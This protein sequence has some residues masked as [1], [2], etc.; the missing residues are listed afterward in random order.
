MQNYPK[1]DAYNLR[2][3]EALVRAG[4]IARAAE[5]ENIAA[6]ALSRRLAELE[7]ILRTAL[8]IRSPRG[9]V[10]TPAGTIL[11]KRAELIN[12]EVNQLVREAW[13]MSDSTEVRGF[14]RLWSNPSGLIG[15][16]PELLRSFTEQFPLVDIDLTEDDTRQVMRACL[17]DEADVGIAVSYEVP[18]GLES[19]HFVDD[20]IKVIC[21]QDHPLVALSRTITLADVVTYPLLTVRLG[22]FLDTVIRERSRLIGEDIQPRLTVSSI[23]A[24]CRLIEVG[25]GIGLLPRS[26]L[27][28]YA[29]SSHFAALPLADPWAV[30]NLSIFAARQAARPRAVQA[31]IGHLAA[32]CG[33]ATG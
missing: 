28:S 10:L 25:M 19:W 12:R 17:H 4:S 6:S 16:L 27:R 33:G 11:L 15:Y 20:D 32:Q 22:G 29:G 2:L 7:E 23:D 3:F 30:R 18:A 14:V 26:M 31:L 5:A 24:A 9:L 13:N 1:I 21:P 8:F